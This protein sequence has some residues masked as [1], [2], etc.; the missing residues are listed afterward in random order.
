M[1]HVR[2]LLM[3]HL[4]AAGT[5]FALAPRE[6]LDTEVAHNGFFETDTKR[7]LAAAVESLRSERRLAVYSY[8]GLAAVSV[9]R[10]GFLFLNGHQ[11]LITPAAIVYFVDLSRLNITLDETTKVVTIHLPPL[12]MGDVTFDLV[13]ATTESS[14]LLTW[15]QVEVEAL[16]KLNYG[17]AMKAFTHQAQ[18]ITLVEAAKSE[19]AKAVTT[20]VATSL[21]IAGRPDLKV[22]ATFET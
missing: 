11:K 16:R 8:K 22:V 19:A 20:V 3:T 4:M 21:R 1:A 14:G 12:T 10:D 2:L 5:G 15:S 17:T 6:R 7:V 9:E 18:G 13:G